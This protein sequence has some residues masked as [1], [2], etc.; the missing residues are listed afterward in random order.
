M[1]FKRIVGCQIQV[2]AAEALR[3]SSTGS[4]VPRP[5]EQKLEVKAHGTM[6]P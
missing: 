3:G 4:L 2:N 5:G 6:L 1:A